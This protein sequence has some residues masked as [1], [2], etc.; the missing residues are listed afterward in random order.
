[1]GPGLKE[2]IDKL[3]VDRG[4]AKTNKS[5][6]SLVMSGSVVVDGI[7]VSKAGSMVPKAADIRLKR[8]NT[9]YVSRGGLK[10]EA[11]L[12]A[13]LLNPGGMITMDVGASTGGF[14]DCLLK[15]GAEK[16]YAIDVGY[17]QLA[18][19]LRN[20]PRVVVLER[21]L[22]IPSVGANGSDPAKTVG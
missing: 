19:S 8:K 20:D 9:T 17:G 3:L 5:A 2:R 21:K 11:A 12:G 18:W 1:M 15:K 13:F 16:V 14:T 22:K 7:N 4:L 10:L 6:I